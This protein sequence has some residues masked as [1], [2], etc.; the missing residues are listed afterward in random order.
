MPW[1]VTVKKISEYVKGPFKRVVLNL[2][3][4]WDPGTSE[5]Y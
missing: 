1:L 5:I 4:T 3:C 2:G